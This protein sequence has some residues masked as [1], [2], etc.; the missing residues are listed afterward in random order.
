MKN[1]L[2]RINLPKSNIPKPRILPNLKIPSMQP[3]PKPKV[4]MKAVSVA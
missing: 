2:P 4:D 3:I 1:N